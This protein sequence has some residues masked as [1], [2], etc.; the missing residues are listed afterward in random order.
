[1]IIGYISCKYI[2]TDCTTLLVFFGWGGTSFSGSLMNLN[3]GG[4]GG[5][6]QVDFCILAIVLWTSGFGE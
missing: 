5:G 2:K 3:M 6:P 1:M 4:G